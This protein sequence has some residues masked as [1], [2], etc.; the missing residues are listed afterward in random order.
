MS[1]KIV[2]KETRCASVCELCGGSVTLREWFVKDEQGKTDERHSA[3]LYVCESCGHGASE[4]AGI[5]DLL[6]D[7]VDSMEI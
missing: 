2:F 1:R 4:E 7:L 5:L 6:H 3:F